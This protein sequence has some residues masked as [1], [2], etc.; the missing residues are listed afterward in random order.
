MKPQFLFLF[1]LSAFFQCNAGDFNPR[2]EMIR[3][4]IKEAKSDLPD[5]TNFTKQQRDLIIRSHEEKIKYQLK[6]LTP[7]YVITEGDLYDYVY[8][9]LEKVKQAN[10]SIPSNTQVVITKE[11]DYNAYTFGTNLVFLHIGLLM[12]LKN[13]D[14]IAIVIGHEIAHI[15]LEHSNQAIINSALV[16]TDPVLLEKVKAARRRDYGHVSAL[17]EILSPRL[18]ESK[19]L[20]RK[21]EMSADSLGFVYIKNAGFDAN[22]AMYEFIILYE[23][24]E[25]ISVP[26]DFSSSPISV[27]KKIETVLANYKRHGS[28]GVVKKDNKYEPY[29]RSHPYGEERIIKLLDDNH[30]NPPDP[31]A[32]IVFPP[33]FDKIKTQL[34]DSAIFAANQQKDFST[35]IY[36]CLKYENYFESKEQFNLTL[37]CLYQALSY[38]KERHVGGKYVRLQDPQ[39]KEDFDRLTYFLSQ[40]KPTEC[41]EIAEAYRKTLTSVS[42]TTEEWAIAQMILYTRDENFKNCEILY[43]KWYDTIRIGAY[44][45]VYEELD[46]Y[47]RNVK[48]LNF[49]KPKK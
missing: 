35:A 19:E 36:F 47:W 7:E 23:H 20:S 22:N 31:P 5:L 6:L 38:F 48:R 16:K 26:L 39:Q 10:P 41:D 14:E 25:C 45:S 1:F 30:L 40:L 3:T 28:L 24:D 11:V 34:L 21:N 4:Q 33:S 8:G 2:L 18:F 27:Q 29:L 46:N 13:D 37:M 12:E 15:T 32:I 43:K 44:Q 17:N 9:L 42:H 49:V